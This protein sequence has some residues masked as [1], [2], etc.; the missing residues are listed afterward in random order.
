LQS[1]AP[2]EAHRYRDLA[3]E[4]S[5]IADQAVAGSRGTAFY[6]RHVLIED[7][8]RQPGSPHP[9]RRPGLL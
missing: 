5:I 6:R 8:C 1:E 4:P 7:A 2:F 9:W 3:S